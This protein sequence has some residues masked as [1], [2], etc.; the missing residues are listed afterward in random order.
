MREIQEAGLET[1]NTDYYFRLRNTHG[2]YWNNYLGSFE[3]YNSGNLR[4]YGADT[5]SFIPVNILTE[6]G[7]TSTFVGD[8]PI[9]GGIYNYEVC[10][11]SGVSPSEGDE[12]VAVGILNS[13]FLEDYTIN[14]SGTVQSILTDTDELQSDWTD[15]GRLDLLIDSILTSVGNS[16]VVIS[17]DT[18]NDIADAILTRDWNDVSGEAARSALNALRILRNKVSESGGVLTVTQEDDSTTAWTSVL[19]TDIGA[20]PIVESDPS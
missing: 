3:V 8:L 17:S 10:Q 12:Q 14:I 5:D 9:S 16:G 6:I 13:V 11:Q 2:Q 19:T 20:N 1:G 4:D 7:S 18:A 15:D